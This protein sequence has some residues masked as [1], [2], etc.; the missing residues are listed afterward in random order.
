MQNL[1]TDT[2]F[3]SAF[4]EKLNN[5]VL[6]ENL[7]ELLQTVALMSTDNTDEFF[8]VAQRNKKYGKVDMMKGPILIEK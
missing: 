7:D 6:M 8:D 1:A 3:L 5:P 4:V 2:A